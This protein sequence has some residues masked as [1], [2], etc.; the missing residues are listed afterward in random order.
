MIKLA[1]ASG[2]FKPRLWVLFAA[3][4]EVSVVL[5]RC[6]KVAFTRNVAMSLI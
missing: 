5:L 6:A 1:T 4:K 3:F 2:Q